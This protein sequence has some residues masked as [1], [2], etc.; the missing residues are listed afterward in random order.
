MRKIDPK[1][2]NDLSKDCIEYIEFELSS[3]KKLFQ[4]EFNIDYMDLEQ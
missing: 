2:S 1:Q 3:D 4:K